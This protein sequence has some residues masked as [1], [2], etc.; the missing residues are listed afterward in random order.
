[1]ESLLT[2]CGRDLDAFTK[3]VAPLKQTGGSSS[4]HR[5]TTQAKL[6][7]NARHL[8]RLETNI[9][10][11]VMLLQTLLSCSEI[12][13]Q[14]DA[15]SRLA[16]NNEIIVRNLYRVQLDVAKLRG[17]FETFSCSMSLR[18]ND[19][20]STVNKGKHGDEGD[21]AKDILGRMKTAIKVTESIYDRVSSS[22]SVRDGASEQF[23]PQR[24]SSGISLVDKSAEQCTIHVIES[25]ADAIDNE[26][27][28]PETLADESDVSNP[29]TFGVNLNAP[30]ALPLEIM[31]RLL[32]NYQA[33]A[34]RDLDDPAPR[35]EDA[36][37]NL[38]HSLATGATREQAHD[39]PFSERFDIGIQ[40]AKAQLAQKR[41][42]TTEQ[43]LNAML[44]MVGDDEEK[45]R[46][47]N[48]CCAKLYQNWFSDAPD[49]K[50]LKKLEECS[51]KA[52]NVAFKFTQTAST[53]SEP[54]STLTGSSPEQDLNDCVEAL[55]AFYTWSGDGVAVDTLQTMHPT[56]RIIVKSVAVQHAP[57]IFETGD[58]P[59][60][61]LSRGSSSVISGISAADR[62]SRQADATEL[63]PISPTSSADAETTLLLHAAK[64]KCAELVNYHV[65]KADVNCRDSRMRSPLHL[66][67]L[68]PGGKD[69]VPILLEA[70][71]D[72]NAEDNT[73]TSPL[74]ICSDLDKD[75]IA[76]EL[77]K[78]GAEVNSLDKANE[79][80]LHIAVR[81]RR[82]RMVECL[83]SE[84]ATTENICKHSGSK[85]ID[86]VIREHLSNL[87]PSRSVGSESVVTR[88]FRRP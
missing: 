75:D 85:E 67:L 33:Q 27:S 78:K 12:L 45:V 59:V 37:R 55:I 39:I 21:C 63:G 10:G 69:V 19:L 66:A 17:A 38:Y 47:W 41:Y 8:C 40:L 23:E 52:Y 70:G 54:P 44:G 46:K 88:L 25:P 56:V 18:A 28:N 2:S 51:T 82:L 34:L 77:I 42:P 71:A 60:P 14:D 24:I 13:T 72:V 22:G 74:H 16:G 3:L 6:D 35:Y 62:P 64:S 26:E 4:L 84:G 87:T 49:L 68:G 53:I 9:H 73:G 76:R 1:M 29:L 61:S 7:W 83:L 80:A 5:V 11:N 86:F 43:T 65:K 30:N 50:L 32:Q 48:C 81:K 79:T 15:M 58:Q 57:S 31:N 20:S 36:E